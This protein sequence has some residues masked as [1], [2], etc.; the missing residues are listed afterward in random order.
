[1]KV[2]NQ[3]TL[4]YGFVS[5]GNINE[6]TA[7]LYGDYCLMTSNRSVMA[8]INKVFAALSKPKA[9][10]SESLK[11]GRSL[12]FCPTDMRHAIINYLDMEIA[13]AKAGRKTHV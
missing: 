7:K 13:E 11:S 1:K 8:D 9:S 3:K 5:T 10:L 2:V 4:Q 12:L 6:K